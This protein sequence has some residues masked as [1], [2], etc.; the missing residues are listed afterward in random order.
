LVI[1][2]L[3]LSGEV[4]PVRGAL[5]A[6]EAARVAGKTTV[7][8]AIENGGEAALVAGVEV[9]V[10]R[11][12][13][14]AVA[15][16]AHGDESRA[17]R[18]T[19]TPST[20]APPLLDLLDVRGQAAARR[21]LEITA[22]GGHNALFVGGP[23]AGKTMLA[24]R[25]PGI[26]PD[27]DDDEALEV[28]RVCSVAGLNIGGGL[29]HRRPFRAPHHSTTMAGLV[30]GGSGI[31]RP[32]EL[33]LAHHGVLFL[34]ELPEFARPVLESLR[35][36]L[37]T[38]EVVLSRASGVLRYPARAMVVASM[39]PCPCGHLHDPRRRCRCSAVDVDR[40]QGRISGPLL[41]RIDVHVGVPPVDLV[42]LEDTA[43]GEPSA[44]VRARVRAARERQR[45]RLGRRAT[46]ATMTTSEVMEFAR[47][48]AAGRTLL[49][50]AVERLSLSA[51]GHDRVLRVARTIADVDGDDDVN[52]GHVAE[53]VQYRVQA[54][55]RRPTGYDATSSF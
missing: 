38:G 16:L 27:L 48:D 31:P 21:A 54:D 18:A 44:V 42:A 4:R 32:G 55:R 22:A 39:N 53:A 5:A 28:T 24:R 19:P 17:P 13:Q 40:Y 37:E 51:R 2:E 1:G 50:R 43:P 26:L 15:F 8:T 46:N 11:T 3:S 9:R 30:G 47:P 52:A 45:E 6:S 12:L 20:S 35:E 29:V 33:S 14:D 7:L 36:P 23:G 34:D 10:V 25:L 41:D 49:L